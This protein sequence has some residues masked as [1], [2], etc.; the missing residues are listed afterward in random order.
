MELMTKTEEASQ[1]LEAQYGNHGRF[2]PTLDWREMNESD[3][4]VQF[5]ERDASLVNAVSGFIGAGLEAG[6]SCIVI[7]TEAHREEIEATLK[8]RALD[9]AAMR[10]QGQYVSYDAAETLLRFMREG[11]P[12][13][14]HF[15]E[16]VGRVIA[17]AAQEGRRVR[18]FGEMVALLWSAGNQAAAIRLEELWNELAQ[19]YTF[20]LFCA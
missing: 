1:L 20:C 9:L 8:A 2:A 12:E 4:F 18:A 5:Y 19:S 11:S 16:T 7:A 15:M 17:E 3:H 10:A 14:Q 13:P 6:E